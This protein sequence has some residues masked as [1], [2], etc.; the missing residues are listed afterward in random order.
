[1]L[2]VALGLWFGIIFLL[3]TLYTGLRNTGRR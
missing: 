1:M 3:V 2:L